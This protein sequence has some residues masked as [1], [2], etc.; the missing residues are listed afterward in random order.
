MFINLKTL[1]FELLLYIK[2]EPFIWLQAFSFN[3]LINFSNLIKSKK[4]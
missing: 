3:N 2:C 1:I 4:L